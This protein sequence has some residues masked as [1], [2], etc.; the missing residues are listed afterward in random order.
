MKSLA[1]LQGLHF[2]FILIFD[3]VVI[4]SKIRD[5]SIFCLHVIP[6]FFLS[7]LF[8][9]RNHMEQIIFLQCF[10]IVEKLKKSQNT[11]FGYKKWL[12]FE[13]NITFENCGRKFI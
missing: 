7:R 11:V 5:D 4:S 12:K 13:I 9:G 6:L 2:H 1:L 10:M 8:A 3:G